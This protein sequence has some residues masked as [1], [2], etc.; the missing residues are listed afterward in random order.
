L[1]FLSLGERASPPR[2][3]APFGLALVL[4]QFEKPQEQI[5]QG[6]H[7]ESAVAPA[8][9]GSVLAQPKV[10]STIQR[11]GRILNPLV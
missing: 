9:S 6:G 11:L 3:S 1:D 4:L 10:R 5:A 2:K 7:D 8:D